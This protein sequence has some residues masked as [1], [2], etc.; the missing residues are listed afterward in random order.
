MALG[1]SLVLAGLLAVNSLANYMEKP[2]IPFDKV[3]WPLVNHPVA[4]F[5][6]G[7][8][9]GPLLA[10]GLFSA[11]LFGYLALGSWRGLQA[12]EAEQRWHARH[13]EDD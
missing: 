3:L 2:L 5:I 12:L 13:W 10:G 7:L 6:V 8:A 4:L 9:I 11:L 1:L